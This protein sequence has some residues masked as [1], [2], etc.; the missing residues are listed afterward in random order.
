MLVL[1]ISEW[2]RQLWT[3]WLPEYNF[4]E[5]SWLAWQELTREEKFLFLLTPQTFYG[6]NTVNFSFG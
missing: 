3:V 6:Q 5:T 1:D 2:V 4:L